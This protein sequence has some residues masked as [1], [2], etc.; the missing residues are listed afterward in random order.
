MDQTTV[1]MVDSLVKPMVKSIITMEKSM[2]TMVKSMVAM[3]KAVEA[4]VL[5][6]ATCSEGCKGNYR[7][8]K[9]EKVI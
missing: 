2:I 1:S 7:L 5:G 9:K 6:T 3:V 8:K 4:N